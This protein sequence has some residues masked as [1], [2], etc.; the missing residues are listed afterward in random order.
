MA[1]KHPP[2]GK[3]G[4][5]TN[6]VNQFDQLDDATRKWLEELSQEDIDEIRAAVKFFRD[7][8]T[9]G[10]FGKWV[11]YTTAAAIITGASIGESVMKWLGLASK[12]VGK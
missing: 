1:L 7:S 2:P 5:Y 3:A 11:L 9:V 8:K 6:P 12:G 10:K 4:E